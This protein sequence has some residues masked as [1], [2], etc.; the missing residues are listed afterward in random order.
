[1]NETPLK[2]LISIKENMKFFISTATRLNKIK[3]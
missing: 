3:K 2:Y 1:M